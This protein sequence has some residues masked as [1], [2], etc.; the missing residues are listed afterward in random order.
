MSLTLEEVD[1]ISTLARLELAPEEREAFQRQLSSIL[2][3]VGM[4]KKL[5]TKEVEPMSHCLE[6]W[7]RLRP[8]EVASCGPEVRER[9]LAA[10]PDKQGDLL[11][12]D[13]IFS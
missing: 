6:I 13:A 5:D 2:E 9:L 3:Y 12:T 7:S 4:L 1:R 8:D 11:K 10:F